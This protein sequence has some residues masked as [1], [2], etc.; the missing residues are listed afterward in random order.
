VSG[1]RGGDAVGDGG[2]VRWRWRFDSIRCDVS[3]CV[4][5]DAVSREPR[6]V[7]CRELSRRVL[8]YAVPYAVSLIRSAVR[9][10]QQNS[11]PER[12]RPFA[13]SALRSPPLT[14]RFLLAALLLPAILGPSSYARVIHDSALPL[15]AIASDAPCVWLVGRLAFGCDV[16]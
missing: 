9:I 12:N 13:R 8:S 15:L 6:V 5:A 7:P 3:R 2:A 14:V 10:S 16:T 11:N 1:E 4:A